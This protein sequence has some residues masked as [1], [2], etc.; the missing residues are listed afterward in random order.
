MSK[1][2]I[3]GAAGF[4]G[5]AL[6]G[7]LLKDEYVVYGIDNLNPYYDVQLKKRPAADPDRVR[8]LYL[9]AD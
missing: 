6:A 5:H 1:V 7:Y 2:L 8:P 3:T 4:V 9:W